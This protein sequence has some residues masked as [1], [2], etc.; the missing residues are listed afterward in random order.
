MYNTIH[1]QN[2]NIY[3]SQ[4][5]S[6]VPDKVWYESASSIVNLFL[7][8]RE[9]KKVPLSNFPRDKDFHPFKMIKEKID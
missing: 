2:N 9:E 1:F 6:Y 3:K 8:S 4:L 7:I 5:F